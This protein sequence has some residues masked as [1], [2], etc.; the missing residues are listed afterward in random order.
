LK[1]SIEYFAMSVGI[2]RTLYGPPSNRGSAEVN[3]ASASGS[4]RGIVF[5][6]L[7]PNRDA[8]TQREP[9]TAASL[10]L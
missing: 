5:G 6:W 1:S 3:A 9:N 10:L 2:A 7:V 4:Y 8:I